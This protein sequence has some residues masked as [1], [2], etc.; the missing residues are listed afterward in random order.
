MTVA[1]KHIGGAVIL[2]HCFDGNEIIQA[3]QGQ[4]ALVE[5]VNEE[6]M[7]MQVAVVNAPRDMETLKR[8]M[9]DRPIAPPS[10]ASRAG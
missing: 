9:G 4:I 5:Q 2:L 6:V 7:G 3:L 1:N 8:C 10:T